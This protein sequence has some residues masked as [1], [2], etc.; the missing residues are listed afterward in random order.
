M[1]NNDVFNE[2]NSFASEID[3]EVEH[4][5]Q[6]NQAVKVVTPGI[7]IMHNHADCPLFLSVDEL[8]RMAD[9]AEKRTI[10]MMNRG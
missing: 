5:I 4:A 3:F 7:N 8:R 1:K 10:E 2:V 9:E 6:V